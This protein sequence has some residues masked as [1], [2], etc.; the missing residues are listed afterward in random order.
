MAAGVGLHDN[1]TLGKLLTGKRVAVSPYISELFE[2]FTGN[3]S[4]EDMETLFQ[5]ITL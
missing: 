5:L 3:A 4:P 2:G 1:V